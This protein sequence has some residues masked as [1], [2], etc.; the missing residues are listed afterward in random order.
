[1]SNILISIIIPVYNASKTIDI[2]FKSLLNQTVKDIEIIAVNDGSTDNS[3][4]ILNSYATNNPDRKIKILTQINSGP[5]VARNNGLDHAEGTYIG[6]VDADDYIDLMM[7]EKLYAAIASREDIDLAICG[8]YD[9]LPNGSLTAKLPLASWSNTTLRKKPELLHRTSP[10]LWDKLYRKS[11]IDEYSLRMPVGIHYAEDCVFLSKFKLVCNK[12][13]VITEPLYFYTETRTGSITATCNEKW[14]DIIRGMNLIE[15]YYMKRGEF[16]NFHRQFEN[17]NVKFYKRR[18]SSLSKSNNKKIQ[19]QYVKQ[20]QSHLNNNYPGWIR[21]Q[22]TNRKIYPLIY[23]SLT[24]ST[25]YI[26]IPNIIKNSIKNIAH[27]C[28]N[29]LKKLNS[30]KKKLKYRR[31]RYAIYRKNLDIINDVVLLVSFS[32]INM[33]GNLFYIAKELSQTS[34]INIFFAVRDIKK[35][36]IFSKFNNLNI[37]LI[38]YNSN[39]YYKLLATSKY[40]ITN[41]RVANFF[42]KRKEQILINTWHGTPLKTL[43]FGMKSGLSDIGNNQ[44]QFLMSDYLLFPNDYTQRKMGDDFFL[45]LLYSKQIIVSGY[46]RNEI[47][48][49]GQRASEVKNLLGYKDHIVICYMPT[50]R[51]ETIDSI[52][53]DQYINELS[54][55]LYRIDE[56]LNTKTI[57]LV[58]LHQSVSANL[59]FRNYSNIRGFPEEYETYE[60]LNTADCLITDYSSVFFDFAATF[61]DILLFTYDLEEYTSSRGTY[62]P[63][64]DLPFPKIS[65]KDQLIKTISHYSPE[66]HDKNKSYINFVNKYCNPNSKDNAKIFND[67]VFR[68]NKNDNLIQSRQIQLTNSWNVHFCPAVRSKR[69]IDFISKLINTK[70]DILLVFKQSKFSEETDNLLKNL[71]MTGIPCIV[72]GGSPPITPIEKLLFILNKYLDVSQKKCD[73]FNKMEIERILPN[74]RIN[75]IHNHTDSMRLTALSESFNRLNS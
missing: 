64:A 49:D 56:S 52:N 43:G 67:I 72:F 10:F 38:K 20:A 39:D 6:F 3:L 57:F 60:V 53:S 21:R 23:T 73:E 69:D 54:S 44:T 27:G 31:T 16:F 25:I 59:N 18:F 68:R 45:R 2:C 74:I 30:I 37:Q 29:F 61:K 7:Y 47:L 1:M 14:F 28:S 8:R 46:P 5:S 75:S 9:V 70:K 11:I 65:T 22:R 13:T 71:Y 33:N 12:I 66:R 42:I 26:Y 55:L 15:S 17:L 63:I 34:D 35:Y 50:W 48:L 58:K 41:S 36:K 4:D 51:G 40:V 24:L 32:G 62:F 19:I